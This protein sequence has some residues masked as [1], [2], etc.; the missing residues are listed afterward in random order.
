MATTATSQIQGITIN[1]AIKAPCRTVS[2]TNIALAGLQTINGVVLAEGNR[3]LVAGQSNTTE[4][5]IYNASTSSWQRSKD[6][7]GN[8]DVVQGTIC[9]VVN[10]ASGS[11]LFEVTTANPIRIDITSITFS[12]RYGANV[13]YDQTPAEIDAGVTPTDYAY[14]ELH[15]HRYGANPSASASTN[16]TAIQNA[17]NVANEKGGGVVILEAGT[18]SHTGQI[19][20]LRDV[21]LRGAGKKATKLL[22]THTGDG[23]ASIYPINSSSRAN[24][25]IGDLMIKNTNGANTGGGFTDLCGTYVLTR[26]LAVEGFKHGIIFDQTELAE[27][28]L[29]DL[30]QGLSTCIWL[31]NG[32]DRQVGV[33]S[34]FT[35][36]ISITRNQLNG[37]GDTCI[38]DDGGVCHVY[39]DNNYN[40]GQHH[41]RAAGVAG[42]DIR[43]GEWESASGV[44]IQFT[45]QAKFSGAGVGQCNGVRID[46]APLIASTPGQ[47][48]IESISG[49]GDLY[50]GTVLFSGSAPSKITGTPNINSLLIHGAANLTPGTAVTDGFATQHVEYSLTD[51]ESATI[52]TNSGQL[53]KPHRLAITYSA[54]MNT[55]VATADAFTITATNNTAFTINAPTGQT[56]D[57]QLIE[58]TILN[59]SGGALGTATWN[60]VFKMA[61]WTSPATGN[62]RSIRFRWNG[63]NWVEVS[64][65]T[66]DIP[67]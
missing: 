33:V 65:T 12:L 10:G 40:G 25:E 44:N 45:F 29:C 31:V 11:N 18:Y 20:L 62:S 66:A 53:F 15:T 4:N 6:F 57:G 48:A 22:S 49:P 59:T 39:A 56:Q 60:A 3:V 14:P 13:R 19:N 41:V 1:E 37:P 67:N 46:G 35:N 27:I 55:A 54:S 61:T 23:V 43:G 30:S 21:T 9:P 2:T 32:P 34:G 26:N 51:G 63:T 8:R 52:K 47:A 24:C 28:D 5:G 17:I 38:V 16:Q 7:D 64:R 36:R 58:Y 50:V 42:L